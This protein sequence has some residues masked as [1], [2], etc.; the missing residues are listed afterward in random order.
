MADTNQKVT[1]QKNGPYVVQG[2]VPL[3]RKTAIESEYGEPLTW[4]KDMTVKTGA[5]YALC[6]CGLSS[7][8]PFCDGTHAVEGFDGTEMA[9]PGPIANRQTDYKGT[10][11]VVK[12][13]RSICVHAGFCGDRISNV[14][15]MSAL[16]EDTQVRGRIMA[17]VERCPSGA[18]A[19]SL[20]EGG[21]DIEPDLPAEIS[22]IKDGPFWISGEIFIERADDLPVE[23]RNRITLCRCGASKNKPFCDG[24]HKEVGFKEG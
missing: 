4:K 23:Q 8:K 11:I 1:V 20:E 14:W 13:D 5:T 15:K 17:M 6:R 10:G 3:V 9:D 2:A 18:L 21:E 22:I 19:Y 16:S 12:D 24:R 7:A